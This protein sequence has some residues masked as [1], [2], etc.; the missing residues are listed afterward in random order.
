[1]GN[2]SIQ[3]QLLGLQDK[4][5][6]FA[7]MLT[8][9]REEAQ[10]L[11]QETALKALDNEDKFIVDTNFKGWVFTLMRNIFINNYRR[12]VRNQRLILPG[13]ELYK[14]NVPASSGY[15]SPDGALTLK[16]ITQ[17]LDNLEEEIRTPFTMHV[18]GFKYHEIAENLNLPIG[19][20]K[21]R[22]F[23]ARK[24]LMHSLKDYK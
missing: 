15:A 13:D 12:M 7:M 8:E 18:S 22:I 19:T 17:V 20:V 2:P 23:L 14:L 9:N 16:E 10:D 5:L 11:F 4:L 6:S 3:Q 21:S 1:M 24:H